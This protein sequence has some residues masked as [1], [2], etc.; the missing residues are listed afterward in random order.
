MQIKSRI[1]FM[2]A[3]AIMFQTGVLLAADAGAAVNP[4]AKT[5][6]DGTAKVAGN[7]AA[8][9]PVASAGVPALTGA[10][11]ATVTRIFTFEWEASGTCRR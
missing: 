1:A 8:S 11:K 10:I 3:I 7:P 4:K 9:A 6:G 5:L 2:I